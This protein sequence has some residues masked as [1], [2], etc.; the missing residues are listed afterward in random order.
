MPA[1]PVA[2]RREL[3]LQT[4]KTPA[5]TIVRCSGKINTETAGLLSSTARNLM[6][7]TKALV[8]DLTNVSYMDSSGL[9][10]IVG[11]YLSA[12]RCNCKL[13][14]INLSLRVKELVSMTRLAS[15]FEGHDDML[16]M[17]PD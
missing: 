1:N 5:E 10:A 4:E 8:L 13:R 15:L 17:T 7:E 11:L 12:R 2:P 16:G 9:G 6:L 3:T 14:L